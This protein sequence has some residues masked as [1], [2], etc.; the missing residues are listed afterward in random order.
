MVWIFFLLFVGLLASQSLMD[1]SSGLL[2]LGFLLYWWQGKID[3]RRDLPHSGLRWVFVGWL[4]TVLLGYAVNQVPLPTVL[5]RTAE[6]RWILELFIYAT[7][8]GKI[9]WRQKHLYIFS[10]FFFFSSLYAILTYAMGQSPLHNGDSTWPDRAV[11]LMGN[12]MPF[13][14]QHG[15]LT[16]LSAA[17][18]LAFAKNRSHKIWLWAVFLAGLTATFLAMTRGV[19]I[20][21]AIG[22]LVGALLV[23]KRVAIGGLIGLVVFIGLLW[24]LL[25][26]FRQRVMFS[27]Q[28]TQTYD[29]ER[30]ALWQANWEIFKDHP[31]LGMG[32]EENSRRVGEYYE[33]LGLEGMKISHAHNQALHFLAGMGILGFLCYL[34]VVVAFLRMAYWLTRST[35]F[36][37]RS[38]GAGLLAAQ[39]CFQIA[40]LTEANFSIA[41][42]RLL[43]VLIWAITLWLHRRAPSC[44]KSPP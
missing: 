3:L 38:L 20:G 12:P 26:D 37:T 33:R 24:S 42:N 5:Q 2:A 23:S 4:A 15:P 9:E 43:L 34:T 19:W 7:L 6:L 31:L 1:F 29:R 28:P 32:Y 41:K 27:M 11:G 36:R 16:L 17:M 18:A 25:P 35:E 8:L 22:G 40:G 14:H 13:A 10:G 30:I 21:L 39:L 44:A